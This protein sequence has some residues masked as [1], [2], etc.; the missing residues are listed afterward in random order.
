MAPKLGL[1]KRAYQKYENGDYDESEST[2]VRQT[3]LAF[4]KLRDTIDNIPT[5]KGD[6]EN[7]L[8]NLV[9]IRADMK[10]MYDRLMTT[11]E[12][13]ARTIENLSKKN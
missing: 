6:N 7:I 4:E 11:I 10:Q 12:S 9:A 8:N 1:K 5:Q 13:Q 3:I 2:P